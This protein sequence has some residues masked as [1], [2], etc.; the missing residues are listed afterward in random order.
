M[1]VSITRTLLFVTNSFSY[2]GSEKH[3]LQLIRRIKDPGT[4]L[5][6]LCTDSDP[7]SQRL[8]SQFPLEVVVRSEGN[9]K[10]IRDW[11]RV[12]KE[13]RPDAVILVYGTLWMLPWFATVAARFADVPRIFAI[14][15]LMP[16]P[17][18]I[19]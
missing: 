11:M 4:R 9:L 10:S 1:K 19:R 13:I 3:L 2:G 14:H 12:Y 8:N 16:E 15:H 18:L 5:V 7:F 17:P 6:I